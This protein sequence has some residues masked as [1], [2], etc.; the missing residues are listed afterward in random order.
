MCRWFL[1][2]VKDFN[3]MSETLSELISVKLANVIRISNV[4][5]PFMKRTVSASHSLITSVHFTMDTNINRLHKLLRE[6][7]F[8]ILQNQLI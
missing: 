3:M 2:K 5:F 8:S 4:P 6:R 7:L 1:N